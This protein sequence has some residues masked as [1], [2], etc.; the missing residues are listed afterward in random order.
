MYFISTKNHKTSTILRFSIV[1]SNPQKMNLKKYLIFITALDVLLL[2]IAN[3]YAKQIFES[4]SE[5]EE[6]F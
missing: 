6:E 5:R 2:L 1:F 3:T 4:S